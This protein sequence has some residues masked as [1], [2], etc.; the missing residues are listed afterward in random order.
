MDITPDL[1]QSIQSGDWGSNPHWDKFWSIYMY[2]LW[3]CSH[4]MQFYR[5]KKQKKKQ[6]NH[7]RWNGVLIYHGSSIQLNCEEVNINLCHPT[8]G[9]HLLALLYIVQVW[10]PWWLSQSKGTEQQIPSKLMVRFFKFNNYNF[11]SF[12][13]KKQLSQSP[14]ATTL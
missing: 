7:L 8:Q 4:A 3:L 13:K 12:V 10:M 14:T 6:K 11:L 2:M 5:K 9:L 1:I